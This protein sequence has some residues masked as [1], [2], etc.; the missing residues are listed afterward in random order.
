MLVVLSPAK[1]LDFAQECPFPSTTA[2]LLRETKQLSSVTQGLSAEDLARLMKLSRPL[3][4]LNEQRF[5][6]FKTTPKPRGSSPASWAFDGD[7]YVGLRAREFDAKQINFAQKHL[8]ILSGLYGA[9]RPL[10]AILPYRLE[11]GTRLATE[12]GGSLYEFWGDIIARYLNQQLTKMRSD[13]VVNLASQEYFQ[14][15]DL[16]VLKARVITP[17]FKEKRGKKLQIISF[18]AKRARGAMAR[19]LVERGATQLEQIK[20]F[21]VDGYRFQSTLSDESTLV[22]VREQR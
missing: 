14:A 20:S 5:R 7:T 16:K 1:R 13:L 21:R 8:V 4:L 22:F 11:M 9:L 18:S 12:R 6:E 15:V 10:D 17:Q 2:P 3:A 19:H